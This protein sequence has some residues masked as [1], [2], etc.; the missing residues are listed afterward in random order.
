MTADL[1]GTGTNL[2]SSIT[3]DCNQWYEKVQSIIF[4]QT[5]RTILFFAHSYRA[6]WYYQRFIYSPTDAPV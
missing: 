2:N 5:V 3:I 6:S 1:K 4:A